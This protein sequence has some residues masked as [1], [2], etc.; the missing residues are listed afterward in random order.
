M[1]FKK[2]TAKEKHKLRR[3]AIEALKDEN[4]GDDGDGFF[5]EH[6]TAQAVIALLDEIADLKAERAHLQTGVG[7]LTG[8]FDE[9]AAAMGWTTEIALK[10]GL[11]QREYALRLNAL[12]R[13]KP[14]WRQNDWLHHTTAAGAC[15]GKR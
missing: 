14:N 11:S 2:L 12:A 4:Y 9:L 1:K 8:Q 6:A 10:E 15:R 7:I 13:T 5:H 3:K